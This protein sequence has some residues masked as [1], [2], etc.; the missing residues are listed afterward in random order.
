MD[1]GQST[2]LVIVVTCLLPAIAAGWKASSLRGDV[3]A[4]WSS[5]VDIVHAG[6]HDLAVTE[7][8]SLQVEIG[9]MLGGVADA[10]SPAVV[11]ADPGP[12]V[13][14]ANRCA[15]ILRTRD[16]LRARLDRHR[17]NASFLIPI[18]AAYVVGL[19]AVALPVTRLLPWKWTRWHQEK[20][21]GLWICGVA[22]VAALAVY[23]VYTYY[24]SKLSAAEEL[25]SPRS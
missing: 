16:R 24:E 1:S 9:Q 14:S 15:D 4:R 17:R 10:F 19:V 5:R 18:V 13:E 21:A 6:L 12:I 3:G 8:T 22:I 23:G 25:A 11:W 2:N 20:V 7:L